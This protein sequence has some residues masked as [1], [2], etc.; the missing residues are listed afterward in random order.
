M[1]FFPLIRV[2]FV[3]IKFYCVPP[4]PDEGSQ[5]LEFWI[6]IR[7]TR[8]QGF[9][10]TGWSSESAFP[11]PFLTPIRLSRTAFVLGLQVLF[12]TWA[13]VNGQPFPFFVS[14]TV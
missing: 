14:A 9:P 12:V 4:I 1:T 13:Y 2:I 3:S 5:M 7:E 8:G 6:E 10:R 11:T